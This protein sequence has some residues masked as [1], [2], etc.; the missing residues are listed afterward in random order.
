MKR[1]LPLLALLAAFVAAPAS[2]TWTYDGADGGNYWITDGT[3][4]I[5]FIKNGNSYYIGGWSDGGPTLDLTTIVED[6][7]AEPTPHSPVSASRVGNMTALP[8]LAASNAVLKSDHFS[9]GP[10]FVSLNGT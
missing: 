6:L 4:R 10:S 9:V 8:S 5:K 2:A 7:A 3:W 1:I